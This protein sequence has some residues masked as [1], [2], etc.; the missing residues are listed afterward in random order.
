MKSQDTSQKDVMKKGKKFP[1]QSEYSSEEVH[2]LKVVK[3]PDVQESGRTTNT[4][5]RTK[6][7]TVTYFDCNFGS[8]RK[9]SP[10]GILSGL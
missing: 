8:Q 9:E 2:E 5:Q 6:L 3:L 10:I 7:D 1:K 4:S